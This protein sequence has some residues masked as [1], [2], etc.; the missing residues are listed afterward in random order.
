[1]Y[2]MLLILLIWNV[3]AWTFQIN[4]PNHGLGSLSGNNLKWP[5]GEAIAICLS[6]FARFTFMLE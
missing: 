5:T 4:T 6:L 3:K 2:C 1:M